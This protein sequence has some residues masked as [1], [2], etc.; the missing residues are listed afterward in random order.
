MMNTGE[1]TSLQITT[2]CIQQ[3]CQVGHEL[4]ALAE[5]NFKEALRLAS[6][7]DDRRRRLK[8]QQALDTAAAAV[9]SAS[10]SAGRASVSD[11]M[12]PTSE[13]SVDLRSIQFGAAGSTRSP[14]SPP[15]TGLGVLEGLPISVKDEYEQVGR[16]RV[17]EYCYQR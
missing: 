17:V 4:G 7:S 1:A 9:T 14:E 16:G 3:C 10:A 11:H 2:A 6:D 5:E 8:L 15:S 12:Q 13:P